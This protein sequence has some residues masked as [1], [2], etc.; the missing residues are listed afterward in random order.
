MTLDDVSGRYAQQLLPT[1]GRCKMKPVQQH[2]GRLRS[3]QVLFQGFA[4]SNMMH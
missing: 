4:S 1:S 3:Q 2:P